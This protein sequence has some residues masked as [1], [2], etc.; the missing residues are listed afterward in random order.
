MPDTILIVEDEEDVLELVVHH[1][2]RAGYQTERASDGPTGLQKARSVL[3]NLVILDLMLP[4][5]E[6]TTVCR[7]IKDDQRTAHIPLLMLTARADE[8]DRILGLELGADDY[9][10]KPFAPRELV[11]RV[12]KL[13]AR[14]GGA[15]RPSAALARRDIVVDVATH[16]ATAGTRPLDLTVTEF[17]L[18]AMLL[19][20]GSRVQSRDM[21]LRDVWGY[22]GDVDTRTV[23]THVRRLRAKLGASAALI[24]TVRGIGYRCAAP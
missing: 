13:L 1:L 19:E 18:L 21:L 12:R 23:D 7:Q 2:R 14:A 16:T 5:L 9:V 4:G 10:T 15:A 8:V 24:E 17:K 6:G 3:P 11:L 20:R 22:E